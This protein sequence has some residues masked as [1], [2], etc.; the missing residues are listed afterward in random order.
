MTLLRRDHAAKSLASREDGQSGF[1]FNVDEFGQARVVREE[2][3]PNRGTDGPFSKA[4]RTDS[5]FLFVDQ[6]RVR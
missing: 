1:D 3:L 2:S 6:N 5:T 4:C